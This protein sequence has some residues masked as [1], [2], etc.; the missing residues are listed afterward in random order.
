MDADWTGVRIQGFFDD[1]ESKQNSIPINHRL[2]ILGKSSEVSS[3]VIQNHIDMVYLALPMRSERRMREIFD[4]LQD[5]TASVFLVPDLFVFELMGARE[6]E[7]AGLPVFALCESPM[8][9]PFG[10]FKRM[11]DVVLATLILLTIWPLI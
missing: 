9:G 6:Q 2:P 11:E 8:T 1:A 10:L 5:S 3:Y 4:K 7:V